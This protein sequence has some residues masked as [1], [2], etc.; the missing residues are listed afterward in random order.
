[1]AIGV[2]S[3]NGTHNYKYKEFTCDTPDDIKQLPKDCSPGSNAFI[4]ST[5]EVYMINSEGKWIKV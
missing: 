2:I 5:S 3:N 4:I 1:M